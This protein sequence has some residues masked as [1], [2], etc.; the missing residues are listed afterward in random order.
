MKLSVL[1]QSPITS[2][3][4]RAQALRET[5]ALAQSAAEA[6][7]S[8]FWLA[9]H[10]N[11]PGFAGTS[12]EI[13]AMAVLDA[14]ENIRVGS[15]GVLL[16]RHEPARVAEAF[17]ILAALHPGRV[18]LGVGRAGPGDPGEF[19]DK[20]IE[21]HGHLGMLAG[22]PNPVDVRLWL[23]GAGTGSAPAAGFFGSGYA[24]AH[25]LN[26]TSGDTAIRAYY[27]TFRPNEHRTGPEAVA[28]VRVIVADTADEAERLAESVR[29]WRARKDLG[30][31]ETFPTYEDSAPERW[32][33]YESSRREINDRRFV[34]GDAATVAEE[35]KA[36]AAR[37]SVDEL[38]INTPLPH[39]D[40][41]IRSFA[42]L[43]ER[44]L[45]APPAHARVAPA[46]A[47]T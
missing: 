36:L 13:M 2:G 41:R 11:S 16:A 47:A 17:Q 3:G 43:S 39:I 6:G 28:A 21:L 7:Y 8:R 42:L 31:D 27:D 25:F 9:E 22:A 35:L 46:A 15:G 10:H 23:L 32:T 38:M 44:L 33:R 26:A 37:L 34:V 30:R 29:L 5:V 4:T 40:D 12:P 14:T 18:D 45:D 20:L 24:H 19:N 1:D